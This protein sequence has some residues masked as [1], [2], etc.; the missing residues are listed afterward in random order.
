MRRKVLLDDVFFGIS[1][2]GIARYWLEILLQIRGS[3]LLKSS[4][5]DLIILNRTGKLS[6]LGFE[7]IDFPNYDSIQPSADRMNLFEICRENNIDIFVSTYYTFA[8]GT[9]NLLPVY[10]LIAERFNFHR[11]NQIWMERELSIRNA[12]GFFTISKSTKND[13]GEIYSI[14]ESLIKALIYP[15]VDSAMF[16]PENE[17][18]IEEFKA[19]RNLSKYF[20]FIG[21]RNGYKNG[22]LIFD[23]LKKYRNLDFEFIFV[24]GEEID[25]EIDLK[26]VRYERMN[27]EE[28]RLLLSGATGLIYPSLYEGF[29]I[30]IIEALGV[31]CP[32][33]ALNNSSI[34]EAGGNLAYYLKNNSP[35]SLHRAIKEVQS[36]ELRQRIREEGPI[37]AHGFNWKDSAEFFIRTL[38][39]VDIAATNKSEFYLFTQMSLLMNP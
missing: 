13:L 8:F 30:P 15:G 12:D 24:G 23:Y 7:T 3:N 19:K 34:P 1:N 20:V 5:L 33:I 35:E 38:E 37:H 18:I 17:E 4:N 39:S 27:D 28:F 22:K 25:K 6:Q 31:G 32:V 36:S 10:D 26:N 16:K 21:N 9:Y 11:M 14:K 29:G 2:T